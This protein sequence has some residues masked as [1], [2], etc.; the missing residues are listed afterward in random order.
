MRPLPTRSCSSQITVILKPARQFH[1]SLIHKYP[2]PSRHTSPLLLKPTSPHH[3]P[4]SAHRHLSSTP[5]APTGLLRGKKAL[6]TGSSRG[7]GKAIAERFAAEGAA[8]VLVGRDEAR[9]LAV[10]DG[11]RIP[12]SRSQVGGVPDVNVEAAEHVVRVGDVSSGEFWRGLRK[13][14]PI[15]I[16]VNAAGVTHYSP[17]FATTEELLEKIV[18]INLL[19]TMLGCKMIGKTMMGNPNGGCIINVASLLGLKGGKGSAGYVA[20]KAGVTGFTRA[21]AA[22]VGK[23]NIRVNVIVPGYIETDMTAGTSFKI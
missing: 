4:P 23:S 20:S 13:Q 19:G 8:C 16:L 6:I 17:L 15:D 1:T 3:T 10:R 11:L 12:E 5:L 21:L 9:L 14:K 7:I 2:S 22:E 18:A